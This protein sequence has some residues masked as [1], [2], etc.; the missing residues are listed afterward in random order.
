M[1]A[2]SESA[3]LAPAKQRIII[4]VKTRKQLEHIIS[5]TFHTSFLR[6]ITLKGLFFYREELVEIST[7]P[8]HTNLCFLNKSTISR[9][10]LILNVFYSLQFLKIHTLC[11]ISESEGL[12]GQVAPPT[13]TISSLPITLYSLQGFRSVGRGRKKRNRK[14]KEVSQTRIRLL[15][16][17]CFRFAFL[18][19]PSQ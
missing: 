19:C 12:L 11:Q 1:F 9:F 17:A 7:K 14:K 2:A 3:S 6:C 8:L 10:Y 4:R 15:R 16:L 18:T 5:N 13:V